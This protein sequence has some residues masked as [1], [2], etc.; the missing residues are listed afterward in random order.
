VDISEDAS[1]AILAATLE[2]LL[3]VDVRWVQLDGSALDPDPPKGVTPVVTALEQLAERYGAGVDHRPDLGVAPLDAD[4]RNV[5]DLP[6][7]EDALDALPW[8]LQDHAVRA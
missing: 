6:N 8:P 3:D 4:A 1:A 5:L 7:V 2:H